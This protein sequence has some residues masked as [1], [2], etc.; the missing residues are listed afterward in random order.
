MQGSSRMGFETLEPMCLCILLR[1]KKCG[2]RM[3][4]ERRK[5]G[6]GK[7]RR[8]RREGGGEKGRRRRGEEGERLTIYIE[9]QRQ[10]CE[11]HDRL[12]VEDSVYWVGES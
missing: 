11:Y 10:Q 8:R 12:E 4:L 6:G 9:S 3:M 2:V 1:E 5:R 7:G